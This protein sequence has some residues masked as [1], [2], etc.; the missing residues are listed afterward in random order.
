M[1]RI[2]AQDAAGLRRLHCAGAR[3][4]PANYCGLD[5]AAGPVVAPMAVDPATGERQ[6]IGPAVILAQNLH[7]QVLRRVPT[8][9]ELR[10]PFFTR[11]HTI[12]LHCRDR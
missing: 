11:C 4:A 5:H 10:Q 2:L 8:P 7:G 6:L 1:R 12:N 3:Q 9:V